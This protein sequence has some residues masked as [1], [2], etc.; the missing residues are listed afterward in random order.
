[1]TSFCS[2]FGAVY[3]DL[4]ARLG[5]SFTL[6]WTGERVG[7][8][9]DATRLFLR[10]AATLL[11]GNPGRPLTAADLVRGFEQPHRYDDSVSGP[12]DFSTSHV[13]AGRELAVVEIPDL[14]DI[15]PPTCE[16]RVDHP[17]Q[18]LDISLADRHDSLCP[19]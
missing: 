9:F 1:M 8:A 4:R 2:G 14:S 3:Q 6:L 15:N 18:P 19:G 10:T 5:T 7:V 17:N 12:I 16:F 11:S 13:L